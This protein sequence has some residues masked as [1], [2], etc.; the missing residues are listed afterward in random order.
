MLVLGAPAR[1]LQLVAKLPGAILRLRIDAVQRLEE[2]VLDL[3]AHDTGAGFGH[4][5]VAIELRM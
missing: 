2:P 1:D 3:V 4:R 5:A